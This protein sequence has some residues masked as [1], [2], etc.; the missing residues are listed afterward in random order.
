MTATLLACV[1]TQWP[2]PL[3]I[4]AGLSADCSTFDY[5]LALF[6]FSPYFLRLPQIEMLVNVKYAAPGEVRPLM[7]SAAREELVSQ[8]GRRGRTR[9]HPR[10]RR[11]HQ[12]PSS[13]QTF[14]GTHPSRRCLRRSWRTRTRRRWGGGVLTTHP[15]HRVHQVHSQ[16]RSTF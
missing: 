8:I 5:L 15:G 7:Y 3:A 11:Q 1:E 2:L 13:N 14:W 4:P 16:P 9:A 10:P 6:A 12:P